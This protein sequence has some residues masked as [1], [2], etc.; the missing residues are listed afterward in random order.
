MTFGVNFQSSAVTGIIR[1]CGATC[2]TIGAVV[3]AASKSMRI[4]ESN[5]RR[6][7][8]SQWEEVWLESRIDGGLEAFE[9]LCAGDFLCLLCF[10][11]HD[12]VAWGAAHA[13]VTA[14]VH[15]VLDMLLEFAACEDRKSTRLNSS[16]M[17][18]S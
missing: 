2:S 14:L 17:S 16:H 7:I 5:K 6:F 1:P 4:G 3:Q 9:W 10:Q 11:V 12:E 13:C 15:V 8:C 18:I